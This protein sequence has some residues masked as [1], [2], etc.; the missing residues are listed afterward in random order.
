M[1][2]LILLDDHL[3]LHAAIR[4]YLQ[5]IAGHEFVAEL[6]RGSELVAAVDRRRP[7]LLILDLELE[8]EHDFE[9]VAVI[10]ELHAIH[11]ELKVMVF[12]GHDEGIWLARLID[13]LAI[14]GYV[15]KS[16]PLVELVRAVEH[17]LRGATYYSPRI[18]QRKREL[19]RALWERDDLETLQLLAD[20]HT[21]SQIANRLHVSDRTVRRSVERMR[22]KVRAT[23]NQEAM[24]K[25]RRQG[26]IV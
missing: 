21:I 22:H 1:A 9:P 4:E 15:H 5:R 12:S 2:R 25:A 24:V 26:L 13:D 11:P 7:D 8:G 6:T 19:D 14:N 16:E 17:A 18:A 23:S 3:S 20:G 10:R